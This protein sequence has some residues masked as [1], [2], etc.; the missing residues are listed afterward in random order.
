M[1]TCTHP[2]SKEKELLLDYYL[3]KYIIIFNENKNENTI[4]QELNKNINFYPSICSFEKEHLYFLLEN[5]SKLKKKYIYRFLYRFLY[6]DSTHNSFLTGYLHFLK[7][8]VSNSRY[9]F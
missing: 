1:P 5:K 6:L 7:S 2:A 4:L 8:N 3:Y 9:L